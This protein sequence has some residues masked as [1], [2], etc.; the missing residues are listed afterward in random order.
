MNFDCC[1]ERLDSMTKKEVRYYVEI[2]TSVLGFI[3]R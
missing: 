1:H 2:W 3:I